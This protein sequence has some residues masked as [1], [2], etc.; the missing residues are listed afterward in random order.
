MASTGVIGVP[1]DPRT[2]PTGIIAAADGARRDG[3]ADAARA[4][5][6]T[7]P[8][9]KE[10][11]VRV[12]TA[13]GVF[14]IGGMCKGSGM[15]EPTH[16]DDAR[17]RHD[18]RRGVAGAAAARARRRLRDDVQRHHRRRRVLDQRLRV[19]A[20]Q[21]RQRRDHRRGRLRRL[22]RRAA[23]RLPRAGARDRARRRGR[24]QAGHRAGHRRAHLRRRASRRRGRS[25]TRCS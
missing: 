8:F 13:A 1:L 6:T 2:V 7:D 21:R 22:R 16:G 10:H 15:I 19:R 5:M 14:H 17:L 12:E 4:I 25:P 20:G 3:H 9:P 23:R 24:D 11:A 18:R